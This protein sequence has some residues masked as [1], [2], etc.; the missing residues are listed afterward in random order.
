VITKSRFVLAL[1]LA[2]SLGVSALAFG[3][4]A[5]DNVAVMVAGV[6]PSKLPADPDKAKYIN[7]TVGIENNG[8]VTGSQV[9]PTAEDLNIDKK[10]DP[11]FIAKT[12]QCP[13]LP[14]N[15]TTPD[16]ARA[17]CPADAY[18]GSGTAVLTFPPPSGAISDLEVTVLHGVAG[19][20]PPAGRKKGLKPIPLILHTYSPTLRTASPSIQ[21]YIT[22]SRGGKKFGSTLWVP[23]A[24]ETGSGELTQFNATLKKS[25]KLVKAYCDK[26]KKF[27][28]VR[29]TTYKD[30]SHGTATKNV[31]CKPKGK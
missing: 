19:S 24:P 22:K 23:N 30:G 10:I 6:S 18:L 3:D 29:E 16:Q 21:V 20:Q 9:N 15:G 11:S 7:L 2:L 26:S 13:A 12:G 25:F 31:K 27:K 17:S 14:A 1:A 8:T 28:F 4:G 5:S